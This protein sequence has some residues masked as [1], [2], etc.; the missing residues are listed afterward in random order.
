MARVASMPFIS[1]MR[2]SMSTTSGLKALRLLHRIGPVS[3]LAND[4]D[5]LVGAENGLEA[6][7]H[8]ILVVHDE[9]ADGIG[10]T[11]GSPPSG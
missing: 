1:G 8:E 9:H 4:L 6:A 10:L 11:H 3:G 5:A 2:M 7:A